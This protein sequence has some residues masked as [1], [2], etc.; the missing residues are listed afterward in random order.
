VSAVATP[1]KRKPTEREII[2]SQA[3]L[4]PWPWNE[5]MLH[6]CQT[7]SRYSCRRVAA[8]VREAI[9]LKREVDSALEYSAAIR[10]GPRGRRPIK[11]IIG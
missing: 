6:E 2:A 9:R 10:K 3:H 5:A 7:A 4:A 11:P 8:A 1:R